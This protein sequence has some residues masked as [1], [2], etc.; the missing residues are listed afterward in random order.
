MKDDVLGMSFVFSLVLRSLCF[1]PRGQ[2]WLSCRAFV[3]NG[4]LGFFSRRKN[5]DRRKGWSIDCHRRIDNPKLSL[6][7]LPSPRDQS[8]LYDYLLQA[9]MRLFYKAGW[10]SELL[11]QKLPYLLP[12]RWNDLKQTGYLTYDHQEDK[13]VGLIISLL[14]LPVSNAIEPTFNTSIGGSYRR[15]WK[16]QYS[17]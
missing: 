11:V 6:I 15:E 9:G 14:R 10:T 3:F 16:R 8:S 13:N 5:I 12:S 4:W 2:V 7:D 17:N 1:L